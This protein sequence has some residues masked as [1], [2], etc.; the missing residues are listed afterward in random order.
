MPEPRLSDADEY[1]EP[2]GLLRRNPI[3]TGVG[4]LGLL[5][6]V[7]HLVLGPSVVP[8][9]AAGGGLVLLVAAGIG[10][11]LAARRR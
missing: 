1:H 10:L 11:R 4:A 3:L 2:R 7:G 5:G 9:W 8:A 6:L